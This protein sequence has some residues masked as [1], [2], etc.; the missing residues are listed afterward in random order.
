M[1]EKS[2]QVFLCMPVFWQRRFTFLTPVGPCGKWYYQPC[3]S[4][5]V[6]RTHKRHAGGAGAPRETKQDRRKRH[7]ASYSLMHCFST[8]RGAASVLK[9][10]GLHQGWIQLLSAALF[11][12]CVVAITVLPLEDIRGIWDVLNTQI[13]QLLTKCCETCRWL[14][15]QASSTCSSQLLAGCHVQAHSVLEKL[16]DN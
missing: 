13:L 8:C 7:F 16:V 15:T 2:G 11:N 10:E 1:A 14:G 12:S 9:P 5:S 4:K 6:L 3:L